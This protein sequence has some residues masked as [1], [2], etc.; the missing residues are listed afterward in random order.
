MNQEAYDQIDE[1][2]DRKFEAILKPQTERLQS[3]LADLKKSVEEFMV[4][5][6]EM[7]SKFENHIN[8]PA[9]DSKPLLVEFRAESAALK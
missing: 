1:M 5:E 9:H 6:T 7:I 4:R 3:E 2:I 8:G